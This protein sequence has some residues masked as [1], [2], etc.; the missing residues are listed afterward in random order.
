MDE[1]ERKSERKQCAVKIYVHD[2]LALPMGPGITRQ[3]V[4]LRNRESVGIRLL[5]HINED[6]KCAI[7]ETKMV[8]ARNITSK[9]ENA[10]SQPTK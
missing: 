2:A 7:K 6:V 9:D 3:N 4:W 1:R 10:L 8:A 5:S